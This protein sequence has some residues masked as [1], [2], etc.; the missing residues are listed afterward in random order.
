MEIAKT[1]T[2]GTHEHRY[3]V[4]DANRYMLRSA[5]P[6]SKTAL[7][8]DENGKFKYFFVAYK[9]WMLGFAQMKKVIAVDGTFLRSKYEGVL[10]S[11]IAQDMKNHIFPVAFCVVDKECD[12]SYKYFFEQM[13]SYIEDTPELCIISDI[14]PSIKKAISIVFPTCHYGFCMRHLGENL[15][16]TFHNGAVV[17]QFYKAAKAYNIDVFNDHFNQ[18]RDLVPRVAEHLK[19][20]GFH[21]WSRAF[22]LGNRYNFM[23]TNA[24][25]SVNSMFNVE[26]EFPI[27]ALFDSINR[28]FTEKFHERRMEFIDSPTIFVPLMEKKYQNLS[29]WVIS[30]WPIKLPTTSSKLIGH[31]S[32]YAT[33]DSL[34]RSCTCRVF[35]T[36]K[37]PC[38]HAMARFRVQYSEDFGRRIYDYSSPYY[39]VENYIIAYCEEMNPVPSEESWEV[40]IE[41]LKREIPPSHVNPS[42]PGRKRTKRRH[43]IGESL[44]TRK[45]K[46][47]ICKTAGHKKTTCPNRI[48]L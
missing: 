33:A 34:R 13:R 5:N 30:Y 38:P 41:I 22:C 19:R 9:A 2:R 6:G 40:P 15:R 31:D 45:N 29:T 24:A 7:R 47:S 36:D 35:D 46:C 14:H 21:R 39:R 1:L 20:A 32:G 27:T 43:G 11:A 12:A 23:T 18:I 16:T 25:E 10:L 28:R 26:R 3:A 44:A 48:I 17:S 4:L 8:V 37:I 42:K